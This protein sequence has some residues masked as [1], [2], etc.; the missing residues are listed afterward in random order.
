M[1]EAKA[2]VAVAPLWTVVAAFCEQ[3][4]GGLDGDE[5]IQRHIDRLDALMARGWGDEL[6]KI[7][8]NSRSLTVSFLDPGVAL[9]AS[10]FIRD[11]RRDAKSDALAV[12]GLEPALKA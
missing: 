1:S 7:T 9:A 8:N 10:R 5:K 2:T 4:G 12:C 6:V 3:L 11:G